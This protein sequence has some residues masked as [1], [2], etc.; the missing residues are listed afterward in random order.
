MSADQQRLSCA[1]RYIGPLKSKSQNYR[2]AFK[3]RVYPDGTLEEC[4][5]FDVNSIN[6]R[7]QEDKISDIYKIYEAKPCYKTSK[8]GRL[9]MVDLIKVQ[10][11]VNFSEEVVNAVIDRDPHCGLF[12]IN[13]HDLPESQHLEIA[14]SLYYNIVD[15]IP[16]SQ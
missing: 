5:S 16:G 7:T 15:D 10:D 8:N 11:E 3:L 6:S 13:R 14:L 2:E 9:V 4:L 1:W 12:Y